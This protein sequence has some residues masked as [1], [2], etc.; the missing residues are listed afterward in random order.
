MSRRK[1]P[2]AVPAES[3]ALRFWRSA[4]RCRKRD[5]EHLSLLCGLVQAIGAL[6]HALQRERGASSIYLGSGGTRLA[7]R[8]AECLPDSRRL[9]ADVRDRL[10]HVDQTLTP[11]SCGARFYTR[12]AFAAAALDELEDA[13]QRIAAL[14]WTPEHAVESFTNL[15]E[16]LLAVSFESA[17]VAADPAISRALIA[18]VNFAQG[19]EYA[20]RERAAA[21]AALSRGR[22]DAAEL[23]NVR[24]LQAAQARSFKIFADFAD[25]RHAAALVEL[26]IGPEAANVQAMRAAIAAHAVAPGPTGVTPDAWYELTTRRIDDLRSLEDEIAAD[27]GRLCTLKLAEARSAAERTDDFD[28]DAIKMAAPIAM[29]I[30]HLDAG[31][32]APAVESADWYGVGDGFPKPIH[33]ILDVVE[34]QSRR[35]EDMN[36]QLESA[37]TALNERKAVE[38]AKGILMRSRRLSESEAY[39]LLRRTAMAQNKRIIDV[40]QAVIDMADIFPA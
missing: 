15:I 38:R 26:A 19:K 28:R 25:P 6:V 17:D 36:S 11:A 5:L 35:I 4:S 10:V 39:T 33:P 8:L 31:L 34:A 22:W 27:L 14:E 20:G 16:L 37:R 2:I 30:A 13:R 7:D 12:I 3:L 9:E 1:N 23:C 29:L 18:L 21:G 40:A 32:E 24:D